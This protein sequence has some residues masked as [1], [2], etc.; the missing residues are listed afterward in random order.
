MTVRC[1]RNISYV[2]RPR[3]ATVEAPREAKRSRR[4]SAVPCEDV[5]SSLDQRPVPAAIRLRNAARALGTSVG[6]KA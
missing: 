5:R 1:G 6:G 2:R 3:L 4:I